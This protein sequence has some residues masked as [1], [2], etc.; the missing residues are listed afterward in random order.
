MV[1]SVK[2][3]YHEMNNCLEGLKLK[4]NQY[5][6]R[7]SAE[8]FACLYKITYSKILCD[9]IFMEPVSAFWYAPLQV[10]LT[11][12]FKAARDSENYSKS[13]RWHVL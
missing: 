6:F 2:E 10:A 7:T 12:V 8:V 11:I 13:S 1:H 4:S 5:T 3:L 9:I